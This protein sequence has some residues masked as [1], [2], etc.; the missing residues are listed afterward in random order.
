[1]RSMV[2]IHPMV[3]HFPIALLTIY[4]FL[5]ILRFRFLRE[6]QY[7]FYVKATILILGAPAALVA[8]A[9]GLLAVEGQG[10]KF[11]A[12]VRTHRNFAYSTAIVY[13]ILAF[14]YLVL[15]V[16]KSEYRKK[17][18]G[19]SFYRAIQKIA[20]VI[21]ETPLVLIPAIVGLALITITGGLG[22]AIVYGPDFDPFVKF[23]YTLFGP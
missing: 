21:I 14:L 10:G 6:K 12:L 20:H 5:E 17:L 18:E 16:Q 13:A 23:I 1:M 8:I 9:A 4:S 19:Q 11:G 3:V 15:W 22:A 7:W 2:D